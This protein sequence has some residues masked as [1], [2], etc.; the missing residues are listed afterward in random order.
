M[1]EQYY[2]AYGSN[3]NPARVAQRGLDVHNPRGAV[4]E[5]Y[6]LCFNKRNANQTGLGHA[7]VMYA[8]GERV[9][10]VLY[11]LAGPAEIL[12]MDP[13]E[14]AP[15]NYGRDASRVVTR[16]SNDAVWTWIYHANQ[17]LLEDGLVP[18]VDYLAHLLAGQDFL[19]GEY[20]D[21]LCGFRNVARDPA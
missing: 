20:Y 2:F 21:F 8:P 15:I 10:G 14:R 1:Q 11:R 17:A 3:M 12:K 9:E 6:R 7:N 19:T 5:D 13:F 4:L 18:P 16:D